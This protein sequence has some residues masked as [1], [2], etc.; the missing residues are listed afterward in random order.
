[1]LISFIIFGPVNVLTFIGPKVSLEEYLTTGSISGS[2]VMFYVIAAIVTI[3]ATTTVFSA[4]STGVGQLVA[5]G[6]ID[7]GACF[8][9]V[10]WRIYSLLF[11]SFILTVVLVI[12]IGG[13]VLLIPVLASFAF[14]LFASMALPVS[15][16]EGSK[17]L[18]ALSRSFGLVKSNWKRVLGGICLIT[19]LMLG[20]ALVLAVPSLIFVSSDSEGLQILPTVIQYIV[21]LISNAAAVTVAAIAVT[22]LY[23]DVRIRSEGFTLDKLISE[24]GV[25]GPGQN[26]TNSLV[27]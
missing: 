2:A 12:G 21:G 26:N 8:L 5:F 18:T 10:A 25:R 20:L 13:A 3:V 22:L 23:F 17:Y 15:I 14:L 24:L 27:G 4:A 11:V 16:Y 9:R 6:R 19:M 7:I 1:M